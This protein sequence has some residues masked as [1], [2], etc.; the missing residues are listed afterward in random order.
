MSVL[1]GGEVCEGGELHF[2]P[3]ISERRGCCGVEGVGGCS[4]YSVAF[5]KGVY[6]VRL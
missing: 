5:G 4:L 6:Y 1:A 2:Y 3:R